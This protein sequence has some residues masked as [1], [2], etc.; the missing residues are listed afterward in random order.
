MP[1][2]RQVLI[3]YRVLNRCFRNAHREFDINA[4]LDAVNRELEKH[5]CQP[6]SE[7][8]LRGDIQR[9][10]ESPYYI[11]LDESLKSGKRRLYR[12]A[13]VSFSLPMVTL[14]DEEKEMLKKTIG[15][16]SQYDDIPQYQWMLTLLSQIEN[17]NGWESG[18]RF[19]EFQNN[20]DLV[21]IGHFQA[22]LGAIINNQPLTISYKPFGKPERSMNIHPYY[23]KQYNDRWFLVAQTEGFDD[24]SVLA[25]DRID[26]IKTLHIPFIESNVDMEDYFGDSV[27]VT[28]F[29][30]RPIEEI[31][32]RVDAKRYPYIATKPI[33]WSQTELKDEATE[34][35]KVIRLK[36]RINNELETM[37]LSYGEDI[38]VLTPKCLRLRIAERIENLARKY[39]D[40]GCKTTQTK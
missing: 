18:K 24:L 3:R 38:E 29:P 16:L 35:Y 15:M 1:V 30:D 23:L 19:V 10:Q 14:D 27:G 22:L 31:R 37:I 39:K 7:R 34:E 12:Y 5:D 25:I 9:L 40:N 32:L 13:D 36:V 21:G 4:L 17:G 26:S 20:A 11:E 28:V 33:H 8:T 6:V 2:D